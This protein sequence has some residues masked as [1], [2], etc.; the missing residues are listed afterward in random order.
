MPRVYKVKARFD[1]YTNGLRTLDDKLKKGSRLDKSKPA[2][3]DD[4]LFCPAGETYYYF[5]RYGSS[6]TETRTYPKR[7]MLTGSSFLAQL[8]D[9]GDRIAEATTPEEMSGLE[10]WRDELVSDFESLRDEC[11]ESLDNMPYQLQEA[12]TGQML[13]ERIDKMEEIVSELESL[14]FELEEDEDEEQQLEDK[15][16]E[17]QDIDYDA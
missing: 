1:R 9:L 3:K 15:L 2:D 6:R 4:T 12:E 17:I 11:Q 5:T 7:S 14:E 8:Y 10:T 13:Q 16:V